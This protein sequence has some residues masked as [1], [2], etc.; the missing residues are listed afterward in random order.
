MPR[1]ASVVMYATRFCPYCMRA[2]ELLAAKGVEFTEIP[3]DADLEKRREMEVK[4]RQRTVPQ[5]FVDGQ[6]VGG[7]D[8]IHAL[9]LAGELDVL[10]F[11]TSSLQSTPSVD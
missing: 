5:I 4:S 9:D 8:D 1:T 6:H 2:R 11:P 7:F 3:V 10:L